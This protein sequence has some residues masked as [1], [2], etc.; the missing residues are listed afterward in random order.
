MSPEISN[1]K[2]MAWLVQLAFSKSFLF[3]NFIYLFLAVLG[4]CCCAGFFLVAVSGDYTPV[5]VSRL[6]TAVASL[7]AEHILVFQPSVVTAPRL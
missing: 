5:V 4:L 7:V 2:K 3:N 6:L 1:V